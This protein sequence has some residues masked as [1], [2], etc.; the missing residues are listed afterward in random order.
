MSVKIRGYAILSL[1]LVLGLSAGGYILRD[2]GQA[3]A[4]NAPAPQS[5]PPGV[6]VA[7]ATAQV[8]DVPVFLDGLG[9]V[10]ALN[11]VE[12]KAQVNGYLVSLPV[13]EGQEVKK[14]DIV[15]QIDPR[16]YKAAL[17]LASAQ[18]EEDQ[19]L[20]KSA[21]LDLQRFQS[22]A[23]RDFA[24]VQQVDD[25]QGTVS[26]TTA[27]I[28]AD[29]AAIETAQL[30]LEYSTIRSPI[31]GR[32]S[33]YQVDQGN[34]IE[35]ASQTGIVS[36]TQ[37]KPISV[38]FTLPEAELLQVQDARVKGDL[39][40]NVFSSDG[41]T[42]L[43]QGTLLTPNNTID[44]TTGTISLKAQ[45]AND[46][47]HLWPG[48]FV[49][50][51]VQ[52]DTLHNAVTIPQLAVVHGPDGLFVYLVKPDHTVAQAN[53]E[54]GYE[55]NGQAVVTKGLAANDVVVTT[56]QSRLAPG[57]RVSVTNADKLAGAP[58]GSGSTGGNADP[59]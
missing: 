56:G 31:D 48:E 32:I 13:K 38:V 40:V 39:P 17:D 45:F 34:L 58:V 50:A 21:Q 54:I 1:M 33:L 27:A 3:H 42:Q 15:A 5:P 30:N 24:P 41:K 4:A 7:T 49:N 20:L 26:K 28:A 57:T 10:Q 36:I 53:V 35:V 6:P 22:L 25:Q 59:G 51:R 46:D 55:D 11:T 37:D 12:V 16:P 52:V 43:A 47:D 8:R 29:T 14:G 9:T 18:R 23:K 44:T 19:A 2:M